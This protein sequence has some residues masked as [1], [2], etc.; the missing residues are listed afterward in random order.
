M[1]KIWFCFFLFSRYIL[2]DLLKVRKS[3]SSKNIYTYRICHQN[4]LIWCAYQRPKK[5][6]CFALGH[7]WKKSIYTN[8]ILLRRNSILDVIARQYQT[9]LSKNE[10]LQTLFFFSI[11]LRTQ[12]VY[13]ITDQNPHQQEDLNLLYCFR[14]LF[15]EHEVGIKVIVLCFCFFMFTWFVERLSWNYFISWF[16]NRN[17]ILNIEFITSENQVILNFLNVT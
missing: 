1:Q 11:Y 15:R 17:R 5:T 8:A 12:I 9:C 2:F 6:A 4:N 16:D 13:N 14:I 10:E 3:K 7:T